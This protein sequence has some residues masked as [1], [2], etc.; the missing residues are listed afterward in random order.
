MQQN[1]IFIRQKCI[2]PI[3]GIFRYH[4]QACK[5]DRKYEKY[6]TVKSYVKKEK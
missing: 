6:K 4:I 5:N 1:Q 3:I 2:L